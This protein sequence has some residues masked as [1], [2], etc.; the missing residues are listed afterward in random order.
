VQVGMIRQAPTPSETATSW[1][2]SD[3]GAKGALVKHSG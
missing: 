1:S 2:T 3:Q